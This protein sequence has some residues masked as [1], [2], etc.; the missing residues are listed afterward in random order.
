MECCG[1]FI[2]RLKQWRGIAMRYEKR[3]VSFHSML[4]LFAN[5]LAELLNHQIFPDD[6]LNKNET[7]GTDSG[8][9][10]VFV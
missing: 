8:C 5:D 4:L 2:N 6:L 9:F 7:T 1:T 3:T 10:V